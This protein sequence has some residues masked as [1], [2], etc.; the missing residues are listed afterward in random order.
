MNKNT[1]WT[2]SLSF[3]LLLITIIVWIILAIIFGFWD[4]QVSI[5]VVNSENVFGIFGA[6][7]GEGPGYG[8]I[9]IAVVI[10]LGSFTKDLKKQKIAAWVLIAISMILFILGF[11]IDIEDLIF[12]GGFIGFSILIFVFIAFNKDWR[13][14]RTLALVIVLLAIINPLLFVNITKPTCGRV[15]FRDLTPPDYAEYTPWFLPPGLDF[16]NKSFPSGHTAM[17]FML[18]PLLILFRNENKVLKAV[19]FVTIFGWAAFVGISRIIVGAH[20]C[21]DVLFSSCVAIIV[22]IMLYRIFYFKKST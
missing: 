1:N 17:G 15:R 18:I 22:T 20:Y 21:S 19:G 8:L 13:Q 11:L 12:Y 10:L 6:D 9:G 7:Y 14:Y 2:N 5:A 3:R 4:L 16:D